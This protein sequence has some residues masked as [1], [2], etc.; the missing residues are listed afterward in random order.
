MSIERQALADRDM[1]AARNPKTVL[2][3]SMDGK[4]P[5]LLPFLP[6]LA[7]SLF[8]KIRVRQQ[9]WGL[10]NYGRKE[11]DFYP[12]LDWW[13]HDPNL[14][15][16]F[17]WI[18]IKRIISEHGYTPADILYVNADYCAREN[19]NRWMFPFLLL[20][21]KKGYFKSVELNFLMPGHS[22]EKVCV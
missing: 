13:R 10:V 20:C 21:V 16:T 22:H 8:A 1:Y 7:K 5:L 18:H 19:K 9:L 6:R 3:I 14:T 4:A 11:Y 17:L 2:S 12:Y 15:I